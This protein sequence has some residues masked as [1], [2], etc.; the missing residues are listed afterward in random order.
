[1]E[2]I[3]ENGVKTP[4][5]KAVADG[6][7]GRYLQTYPGHPLRLE[8]PAFVQFGALDRAA[9]AARGCS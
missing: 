2:D 1:M 6:G 4:K 9:L 7:D 5:V 8:H 3:A